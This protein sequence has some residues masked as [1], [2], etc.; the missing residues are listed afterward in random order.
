MHAAPHEPLGLVLLGPDS[1]EHAVELAL[2]PGRFRPRRRVEAA[3]EAARARQGTLLY[4]GRLARLRAL[5]RRGS[6]TVLRCHEVGFFDVVATNLALDLPLPDG[7]TLRDHEG[8][9]PPLEGSELANPLGIDGL[10]WAADGRLVVQRRS[11]RVLVRPGQLCGGFSGNVEVE[12][13][14]EAIAAGGGLDRLPVERELAEELRVP[15]ERVLQ[16]RLLGLVREHARGGQPGLHYDVHVDLPAAEIL[17]RASDQ[18]G[19]AR[20]V[21]LTGASLA[22]HLDQ[23]EQAAGAL[24]SIPLRIALALW[25]AASGGQIPSAMLAGRWPPGQHPG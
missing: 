15:R 2:D 9:L 21:A 18:E 11:D 5:D 13:V 7:R 24:A 10:V 6:G 16:R 17:A 19:E 8:P 4:D 12:D 25:T 22:D 1:G 14:A 20:A 3:L 23:V